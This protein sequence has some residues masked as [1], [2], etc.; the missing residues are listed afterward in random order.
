[1]RWDWWGAAMLSAGLILLPLPFLMGAIGLSR[2]APVFLLVGSLLIVSGA[3]LFAREELPRWVTLIFF[4]SFAVLLGKTLLG[5]GL[6]V[7]FLGRRLAWIPGRG[8]PSPYHLLWFVYFTATALIVV[9][10]EGWGRGLVASSVGIFLTGIAMVPGFLRF[11]P[12]NIPSL[13]ESVGLTVF[14]FLSLLVLPLIG[15]IVHIQI[16][17]SPLRVAKTPEHD[18][19]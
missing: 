4:F 17:A 10:A 18:G 14:L 19:C 1:M 7:G 5:W 13:G 12:G 3:W 15:A 2:F 16:G 11:N 8:N 9:R 6:T